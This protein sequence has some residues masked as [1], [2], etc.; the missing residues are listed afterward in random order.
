[1]HSGYVLCTDDLNAVLCFTSDK[2]SFEMV[3]VDSTD[4]LNK[5]LCVYDLTEAYNVLKLVAATS[6]YSNVAKKLQP[7]NIARLYNKFY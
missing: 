4:V 5:A 1:M 3:L 2:Q 7:K 6:N